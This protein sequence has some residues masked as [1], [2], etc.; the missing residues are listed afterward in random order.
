MK[1][2]AKGREVQSCWM[3]LPS[4]G[5]VTISRPCFATK[6]PSGLL[7]WPSKLTAF[8]TNGHS[9]A[10]GSLACQRLAADYLAAVGSPAGSERATEN[11]EQLMQR[12]RNVKNH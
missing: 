1:S 6:R 12:V 11:A 2:R 3:R 4:G 8:V 7:D 9:A 5:V 10:F